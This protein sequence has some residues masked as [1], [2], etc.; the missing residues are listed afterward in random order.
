MLCLLAVAGLYWL[1]PGGTVKN[2]PRQGKDAV[3]KVNATNTPA[4]GAA[5]AV[6]KA[7]PTLNTNKLAYRLAN[8]TNSIRKLETMPHAV[9]LANAFI[10]TDQP[11]DLKI[12]A[13]LK[14]EGDPGAYIVQARKAIDAQFR[15]ALAGAQAQ[16]VSYIP[17]NAYLVKV[18][19]GGA[20][21]LSGNPL[22]QA[23]LP[24]EPYYKLQSS[25]LGLAVNE[26]TLPAG[27]ALTL[28]LFATDPDA[29]AEVEKAG[30]KLV[31]RDQS[32]FGQ[33]LRVLAPTDWTQLAQ[34]PGVQFL[35]PAHSRRMANDLS[36]VTM[37]IS[38][39][40]LVSSNY[41]NLYGS[42]V[43]VAVN[44]TGVDTNHPDFG[45]GGT[46]ASP[47]TVPPCR[48]TGLTYFDMVD[49]NGHGTHVAGIIAGNGSR[50]L[51]PVN[52]GTY[53]EG[54]VPNA[55]YRGKAPLANLFSIRANSYSD[56]QLQTNAA[57]T[58]ALISNNS[59]DYG[60]GDAAYDLAAASYDYATRDA[61]PYTTGSQPVLFVF[62][63]GNDGNGDD[64]GIGGSGD[65]ILSPGTAKNVITVGALEQLRYIT[66]VVSLFVTP[67]TGTNAP[68]TNQVQFWYAATDSSDQ[69]AAYSAL[70]NVGIGTEGNYG[71]FKPDV[72]APGTF[73]VSTSSGFPNNDEWN[74]NAYYNPTNDS[75]TP[76]T[77]QLVASNGLLYIPPV[78]VP[79][80]A[81]AVNITITPNDLSPTPFPDL[82]IY[83]QQAGY[84]DPVNAPTAIDITTYNNQVSIPPGAGNCTIASIQ[85]NGFDIAVGNTNS[86]AVNFDVTVDILTT[87]DLGNL[88]SVLEGM[89]DS[90]G[91]YYRYESGTSMAAAGVSGM[92][93]LIQDYFTNQFQP[94]LIPSPALMKAELI[95]GSRSVAAYG[96]TVTN[97]VN[98]QGWGLGN[99]E[100]CVPVSGLFNQFGP[101]GSSFFVE[102][103]PTNALA[104]GD[105]HTFF[106][107]VDTNT[108]AQSLQLQ[109][110]LVWTDPPGDPAA[111]IKLVNNLGL[112]ITNLDTGD[113]YFG[114]D[115]AADGY[116][117][118]WDTNGPPYIDTINNVQNII[119]QP[120]L[121]GNY[122]VTVVGRSVNVNA[123]TAQ[124][125]NLLGQYEPNIVQDFALVISV[126]EGEVTNAFSVADG[127]IAS[128]PTGDQDITFVATT[129]SPLMNQIVGENSPE[130]GTNQLA[131]GTNT[132]WGPNGLV[133]IGQTN[134]W[135]F[136][137]VT[138]TGAGSDY[139]NAA[140]I[141]FDAYTLSIPRM[142]VYADSVDNATRAEADIDLYVTQDPSIT[143]L[144]PV[145]ISNCLY[146]T[147]P[148]GVGNAGTSLSQGG[149][150]Y[151]FFTNSAPGQ[152]YYV[153]VK[154]EDHQGSEYAFLPLFTDIPFSSLDKNGNQ[155]VN[156][157]LL[158][159]PTA[160]GDYKNKGV[161]NV[162][163]LATM[164]MVVEKVTVTNLVEHENFG[165]ILSLLVF[166]GQNVYLHSHDSFDD[167]IGSAP[168]VYDDSRH[169]PLG[170]T[171]T[172]GPGSLVN[173]R[174]KSAL[175]PWI[176]REVDNSGGLTG[177]VSRLTLLIQPHRNLGFPG[178]IVS[179]P[180][181]GW[182]ID[183]VDVP[184]GFTNLSIFGTNITSP[185]ALQP[186]QMYEKDGDD[187]TLTDYDQEA[188][189]TNGT[190]PGNMIS[191][192]PP[193]ALGRYFVGLYNPNLTES[194]NVFLMVTLGAGA[195]S[196]IFNYSSAAQQPLADDAVTGSTITVPNTVTQLV[197]S[198]NVGLVVNSSRISDYTFTL[199][200]PTGQRVLLME[201]R[202]GN[203]TNG[204]GSVFVYT[205]VLSAEAHGGVAPA[206]NYLAVQP[207]STVPIQW[208]FYRVA[209]QMTI[210][211][212]TNPAYFDTN[213]P[214]LLYNTGLTNNPYV[215]GGGGGAQDTIPITYDLPIPAGI[216]NITIIMNQF[217]NPA[218]DGND[219]WYYTAGAPITNYEYLMF[220]DNTN[221]A[222]VPI[223]FAPTPFDFA[224]ETTN[225]ALSDLNLAPASNYLALTS[226]PDAYGGWLVPSNLVT[227]TTIE[228]NGQFE[229]VTNVV[230]ITNNMVSVVSDV[231]TALGGDVGES[232]YLALADGTITRTFPTDVG[233]L[234]NVTFWYRGPGIAGWWRGEGNGNDS[235][236]PENLNNN[237]TLIGRFN[238]PA[239]EVD[240][241]FGFEDNGNTYQFAGTNTYVQVRASSS[242]NV[243]AGG[244]FSVEGW[245]NPT[246]LARPQP[247][248][249]WLARVPTNPATADPNLFIVQGPVLNP[250]TGHYYY[251]L[252]ATNWPVSELWATEMGGH[253]A[254]V[255]T[256]NEEN[257]IYD[258]FTAYAATNRYLWIGY[259]NA[260]QLHYGWSSGL[261]NITY[262]NWLGSQ[263]TNCDGTRNYTLILSPTNAYPGLW[264]LADKNGF[265]CGSAAT[266]QVF[267]VVEVPIIPT[268][269]VQL[270]ICGTN[271]TGATNYLQG[272][273][274]ANIVDTN[275]VS[276]TIYSPTGLLTTNVFQ[277]IVLT[278]NTNSG[279][280]ALYLNGTNV[281]TSN[282]YPSGVSFVPKTDGDLLL[283]WDMSLYT[284]NFYGGDMDE[285]SVYGRALS[286]AEIAAIYQVS[287]DS[288]NRLIGKFDPAITPAVGLAE[289]LVTFGTASNV[290]YGV[291][292]QWEVNSYTFTAVTNAMTLTIS[293]LE[294]GVLLDQFS[295]SEAPDTNLY[296]LPEEELAALNGTVAGGPW[297]LQVWDNRAGAYVT[298]L[299]GLVNWELSFVLASN[300]VIAATLPPET[301]VSTTVP[302]GLTAY[303][304]VPVPIWAHAATNIV[305]SAS[306][307]V[308]VFYFSP[309]NPPGGSSG[310]DATLLSGAGAGSSFVLYTNGVPPLATNQTY[311]LGVQNLGAHAAQLVLEVDYDILGLTNG[312]VTNGV[313]SG[314]LT[315]EYSAVRYFSF[316][317]SSNAYEATFQLLQL[318][319][320]AD[321]V[322]RKGVP[323]PDL[324]GADYGSFNNGTVD[325]N[326]YLLTNSSPV[327]LSAGRWYL[328]VIN[329]D[330][331]PVHYSVLAKELDLTNNVPAVITLTND[332]PFTWTA[333]PGADLTNFFLFQPTNAV[334]GGSTVPL[335]GLRF[336][337]YNLSGNGDLTLQTNLLPPAPPWFQTSQNPGTD[338][339]LI[340]VYTNSVLT[341]LAASWYL[342]VPNHE[343]TN[344]TYTIIAEILTNAYFPA[345]PDAQGA[346]G[347][348][349]GGRFG[350]VYHVISAADSGPGTLRDAVNSAKT[351]R[352]V[353]FDISGTIA[354]NTPLVI[355]NSYLT[356]AGETSPGGGITVAG[357]LT[358]V[359]YAHD[360]VIRDV[361]FRSL[362]GVP[363]TVW[364]NGFE[365]GGTGASAGQYFAGGWLDDFGTVE[366]LPTGFSGA[367]AYEGTYYLDL[368]G[369]SAGGISTNITTVAGQVY[370][371]HFAYAR[372]PDSIL[373]ALGHAPN[374]PQ[375]SVLINGQQLTT[376]TADQ[377]NSWASLNWQ[378][379]TYVFTAPS[380]STHLAFHS[381][382]DPNNISGVLLDAIS[383]TTNAITYATFQGGAMATYTQNQVVNGWTV[384]TNQAS[385]AMDRVNSYVGHSN[386]LTMANGVISTNL[387][388]LAGR[389]YTL[390]VSYRGPGIVGWWRGENNANDSS[391]YANNPSTVQQIS[392]IGG[393]V[394]NALS[395]NGSSYVTMPASPSLGVT[396]LTIEGWINP[397]T[398]DYEPIVEWG[399]AGQ[400]SAVHFWVNGWGMSPTP[401]QLYANVRPVEPELHTAAGIVP[402]NAW[403]HVAFTMDANSGLLVIYCNGVPAA[404]QTVVAPVVTATAIEP[405][406]LGYRPINGQEW[407]A[408]ATFTGGMDEMSVYNRALSPSEIKAIWADGIA[409]KFD[410][411]VFSSAPEQSLAEATLSVPG[412]AN[413]TLLG[414]NTNWQQQSITFTA[415]GS[416]TPVVIKGVEPGMLVDA[417]ALVASGNQGGSLQFNS[418]SNVIADHVSLSWSTNADLAVWSSTNVTVQWSIMADSL[419]QTNHPQGIG[420][421]LRLGSGTLSFH[422]NLYADNF[423]ASPRFGDN[424]TL[425]F[426]N[427]VIYNW[428]G[429]SGLSG[430]T[431]DLGLS[432]N[433]CTNVLNY[434][435]NYL[436]AGP[437]TAA[438][439]T[440]YA[441]TNIAYFG[442]GTNALAA[443]WVFQT[444]NFID[445]DTNGVLNGADTGWGMFTNSYTRFGNAFPTPPVSVDEAYQGYERVLDFAGVNLALRDPAD[446][447][448][449]TGVRAQ[450]GRIIS[451][452]PTLSGLNNQ[453]PYLD[454]DQDGIP[455]FWERT[456]TPGFVFVPSNKHDRDGD[457][458][459]DLEEYNNWLA[460]PHALTTVTNP[461]AVDLYQLC[462]ESGHLAFY[463]TNAIHGTVYLTN[464]IGAVVNRSSSWSNTIAI[465]TPTNSPT[466]YFGY[467][468]FDTYVTNLDTSAY[469][470]PVTVS[471]IVSAA[472]ILIN[473][474]IPPVITP[475]SSGEL[476]PTNYGGS[477]FVSINVTA[478]DSG[479]V[480]QILQ[481]TGPMAI[482]I[483][484]NLPLP[485]L[486]SY[487]YYTNAPAAPGNME[488]AVLTNSSPAPL[489]PGTWYMAA[490]NE[491]GSNVVYDIKITLLT[492]ILPPEFIYPTNTTVITNLETMPLTINCVAVD[493]NAPPLPLSFAIVNGP[494][495]L[496]LSNNVIYWT[497]AEYLVPSTNTV[498]VSV[499]NGAF[500][501]TNAF[502][503]IV[504]VSNLPPILPPVPVQIVYPPN[505]LVV[506]DPAI[507][508]N[509]PPTQLTYG[510]SSSV[511]DPNQPT[512][513][514]YGTIAWTPTPAQANAFYL[515][516][517]T[518]S[519]WN[520]SAVNAQSLSA[521]NSFYVLV[522]PTLPPG[523]PVTNIFEPNSVLWFAIPV[524][525]N[526]IYATN[527][528]LFST[529]PINL[530]YS[531]NVPPSIT[532]ATDRELLG[533]ATS[534]ISVL[535]TNL[536]NAP[537][538]LVPGGIY[539][540]GVQNT[541]SLPASGALEV[542]FDLAVPP[543]YLPYVPDQVIAGGDTLVVT[544]TAIDTNASAVLVYSLSGAPAGASINSRGIITWPTTAAIAPTNVVI[545]T[546]VT[547]NAD[548]LTA[549][550]S[551]TVIV[552]PGLVDNQP[553]TNIVN[554]NSTNWFLVHVPILADLATN[555]LVFA[556][557]QL[558][559]WYST[560]IPPS[561]LMYPDAELL[562]NAFS[563]SEVMNTTG[564]PRLVPGG[565]YYL[566]VQNTNNFA[567]TNA[568]SVAFHLAVPS[569]FSLFG[570]DQTNLAGTNGFMVTWFAP[571]N[572]Q[573]HLQWT[574]LLVPAT[575]T[576]FNGV[577]SVGSLMG[578]TN[579][580]FQY[581]DDG[582]QT[583][584]FGATRFYRLLLLNS[585][586]NTAPFFVNSPTVLF[587]TPFV[588]FIYTNAAWDWDVPAQILTYSVTNTLAAT[589]LTI[590]SAGVI[591]W[592]AG[593]LQAGQTNYIF[594]TVTDNGVPELGAS[595]SFAIVVSPVLAPT[596]GSINLGTNG[597]KFQWTGIAGE[598]FQ[599][600]W[601][602]NLAIPNWQ[603]FS[604]TI[605]SPSSNF[606]FVD[607]NTPLLQMKFY[608]LILLP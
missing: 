526:A 528:L 1:W 255:E 446:T 357:Q 135:H 382:D 486:S 285:M 494:A 492:K 549:S 318:S 522:L 449:V 8:T 225:Y 154:S 61:L 4:A 340:F 217:G 530:W 185:L 253:L 127:G 588:P 260:N 333:G 397:T 579:S 345:F 85:N 324:S 484:S 427:N 312:L 445:S 219:E 390:T 289:A 245:I 49:T 550:N 14:A 95:N 327:P 498:Q 144:S 346:G 356:I 344:I 84:P 416:S 305:V 481:P 138:N 268:N 596:F 29:E 607:T 379:A 304:A 378:I 178:I 25:L 173:F 28:G 155:I 367:S 54:S 197:A 149:T 232:N 140:F 249:E 288:T 262:T 196:D 407:D 605:T 332:V 471:V 569:S 362:S 157:L 113:V 204:A 35:E 504:E 470:G 299:T 317:V 310:P 74:T 177:Q 239:G 539:F 480:F 589:N 463:V 221:L 457:G 7:L 166:G 566:G 489:T 348:A 495:G 229:L 165:D 210:Y 506:Y 111:A 424:L 548:G 152:I 89:N 56:Y 540:L 97:A 355:S 505:T 393:E 63:A 168:I 336:E 478:N 200:S 183:Y 228:T 574:P 259:T 150:E 557:A 66:N 454:T 241:A 247:V 571:T 581:F 72:V 411:N 545:T 174:S 156:G 104:T 399:G 370:A 124:T 44:D 87:N 519:N 147:T 160:P 412:V 125:N 567:V 101:K 164:P 444:N 500:S 467:A 105:G 426:V 64:S 572:T 163:A 308:N 139:T 2:A 88:Y 491:S 193:L 123:V 544:N 282:L 48:V 227:V 216:T 92:L 171:N 455:D 466:N 212:T 153:G 284:N 394:G 339:E 543:L 533:N 142:G 404:S 114:N 525:T 129:N 405:L 479:A 218:L 372:N 267:G 203:D 112:I 570:I 107:T 295:V 523:G 602:T 527:T 518:V 369:S 279:V 278:F 11:L 60:N 603:T 482:V 413:I 78:Q 143:N 374:I 261:T 597:V 300:A 42:N 337:L 94:A 320:N 158:P 240:Q 562:T 182:F 515:F 360:V 76:Y 236:D 194:Q 440:N 443:N 272:C 222:G 384:I 237:G 476:D 148:Y 554:A 109:A 46:A 375:L 435:C 55:D 555:S 409:G 447:N 331:T 483:S 438:C 108:S 206:T 586:S 552:L 608:Q 383:L 110:T 353:V 86:Y 307:P 266:N 37:G 465:F 358:T 590:N 198:V 280:A 436:I 323:L 366:V 391:D 469:F 131:L 591:S 387:P 458:Y 437:D 517:N 62:A 606:S 556:T 26:S 80:N 350:D 429:F 172:D 497:P 392:Y 496:T 349:L 311:Y 485:S 264:A 520:P 122:S 242:L 215:P 189:L 277:H 71:R 595:N 91:G 450:S 30:A 293:G 359:Q 276:H 186:I 265:I 417:V 274:F 294:P 102:Q 231:G 65:T 601:T 121:A 420:S 490:V 83:C 67:G 398:T 403:T 335:H 524:P 575:W 246:N 507:D 296:Y 406:N 176:L 21:A 418:V 170:T 187:P 351:N 461:V 270:W 275:Y 211:D 313:F 341:N 169:A 319:G 439:A 145:A 179:V 82:T 290:I 235:S 99:I 291:N 532:N 234:Y 31:G 309:A 448:I 573:F 256:A 175:G 583:A 22:V 190:P 430:G 251:L 23:V 547:D 377:L 538:N 201:N 419:Y 96:I 521:T 184:A 281:A 45:V 342:G 558:N 52:V 77:Y 425:D 244:G 248:A 27:T 452:V 513:D 373:G 503:I 487:L 303:Y 287:A 365:A 70:G 464:V 565:R 315:N 130:L 117:Q 40:T 421:L 243:G 415:T 33:V 301:P 473:S 258:T 58:G 116:N 388:T 338:P 592:T 380:A 325:E 396:N 529:Q 230:W 584:G 551:F 98:Y 564:K 553:Q 106:V 475:L 118:P 238:F 43:L 371:L 17:N 286:G 593:L 451:S 205:N 51:N 137:V 73:V 474:N 24:Y 191:V 354:L 159:V 422:H 254:T 81:V 5:S 585:P 115:I 134:Q 456:F 511:T 488:I 16:I 167:T 162:F 321:L 600:R 41:M 103:N 10:D 271:G 509:Y 432:P 563:G 273:L 462:G 578:A 292:D 202:G 283:G 214:Y 9:L 322:V 401:G 36:R 434:V 180:P 428:G 537:T 207:N 582:S 120:M 408:G 431:N 18:T 141:T 587:A 13:H 512:I 343:V 560:N 535:G 20:G 389:N 100:N 536:A 364:A 32:P 93:A 542:T 3:A 468:S 213:S 334:V 516:T 90:L 599:I 15:A 136:Y 604:S 47:D 226:I 79:P 501:V 330:G 263:P 347:A 472:P 59:W 328:G 477:D 298:N 188:T 146:G 119:L 233:R 316:D 502:T 402:Q 126:G 257:W 132:I 453:F 531:T 368:D 250:A 433:G 208:N 577:I 128:N 6:A 400:G 192:G 386:F 414:N 493:L 195:Q 75:P 314:V 181:G 220:T 326:I 576:N 395:F 423:T 441:I 534:G 598:Q 133:T 252:A 38:P 546:V 297:T 460:A 223:K 541:G 50:S 53:A 68:T 151:V 381:L 508:P 559:L 306:E 57:M 209:D 580:R 410:T 34:L 161:T 594:T 329:R 361:R 12:P 363:V 561:I 199:V 269:G 510:L 442:G 514:A 376:L 224:E 302:T 19:V 459:T 568:V 39:D 69:V 385:V 352:T 499:S